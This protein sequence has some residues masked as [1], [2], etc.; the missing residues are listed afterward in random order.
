MSMQSLPARPA[1]A[2]AV[3]LIASG[4]HSVP[5]SSNAAVAQADARVETTRDGT[6]TART[7]TGYKEEIARRIS[8]TNSTKVYV[9]QPQALLR[10]VVVLK[11]S[12]D[13]AGRLLSVGLVRGNHDPATESAALA[14]VRSSAP[15]PKPSASL[16][17]NGRVDISE[18]WLFNNDGRFQI[19]SIAQP[20][21]GE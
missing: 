8:E 13:A 2:L 11:Y 15:F 4:C 6:S 3:L 18:T 1:I 14:S 21:S 17:H 12:I 19:R 16:L 20:Q 5:L 7:L 9:G 10:A